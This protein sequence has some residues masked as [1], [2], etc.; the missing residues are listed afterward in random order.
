MRVTRRLPRPV[1]RRLSWKTTRERA[2]SGDS[3][4]TFNKHLL[5]S[6]SQENTCLWHSTEK[7]GELEVDVRRLQV[8]NVWECRRPNDCQREVVI[9]AASPGEQTRSASSRDAMKKLCPRTA[10][11][12]TGRGR[13]EYLYG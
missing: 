6:N 1:K 7:C 13:D 12:D 11:S 10:D 9:D 3:H 8:V 5:W 4:N 2:L